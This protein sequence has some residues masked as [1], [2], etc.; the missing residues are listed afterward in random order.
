MALGFI[1]KV[2][3]I[4]SFMD[5][6]NK[7]MQFFCLFL[8]RSSAFLQ[9]TVVRPGPG[10]DGGRVADGDGQH[11]H[12]H[13]RDRA[14]VHSDGDGGDG[15]HASNY[16]LA[17][18]GR[19][20]FGAGRLH[21]QPLR[22]PRRAPQDVPPLQGEGPRLHPGPVGHV[23]FGPGFHCIPLSIFVP[24]T[25]VSVRSATT[26]SRV[27]P[28]SAASEPTTASKFPPTTSES[29]FYQQFFQI[30]QG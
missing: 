18:R 26:P 23:H 24:L 25:K 27:A 29:L 22:L 30:K 21:F 13:L 20:Y 3:N 5:F 15:T 12:V 8:H 2:Q 9:P 17:A 19:Q 10:V 14:R 16:R 1:P 11:E 4:E 7:I 28:P 6:F